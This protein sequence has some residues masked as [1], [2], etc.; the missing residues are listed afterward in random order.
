MGWTEGHPHSWCHIH[1]VPKDSDRS[2]PYC[3]PFFWVFT[4]IRT[5][6]QT[7]VLSIHPVCWGMCCVWFV[8]ARQ[9]VTCFEMRKSCVHLH[10]ALWSFTLTFFIQGNLAPLAIVSPKS[11]WETGCHCLAFLPVQSFRT[12]VKTKQGSS[13][14]CLCNLFAF[15]PEAGLLC[16]YHQR[17][18]GLDPFAF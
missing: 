13:A 11:F 8:F 3:W 16:V 14:L 15:S 17:A 7:E 10:S 6:Y 1:W 5:Q 2:G 18:T 4:V 12:S 9:D